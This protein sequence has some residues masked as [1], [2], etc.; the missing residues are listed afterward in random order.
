MIQK[1]TAVLTAMALVLTCTACAPK[2]TR[3]EAEFLL[4][5]DTVTKI[6]S[7]SDSKEAFTEQAQFVHDELEKY[8]QLYDIYNDYAGINNMKTINDNAGKAPVK[9]DEKIIDLLLLAKEMNE[10]TDG[11]MNIALGGVLSLWHDARTAG[12]DDPQNAALPPIEALRA[13]AEH[14]DISH[15]VIDEAASTVYLDDPA[16]KLDV[17]SI[18]KGYAT[19]QVCRAAEERGITSM[20]VSVGGNVRAIGAKDAKG[21]PWNVGVQHPDRPEELLRTVY[22][23]GMSLVTSG[24]YQRYYTV[25]GKPYHHIIDP[26]TLMPSAYFKAVTILCPDSGMADALSTSVF[27]MP[28]EQGKALVESQPQTE[29]LWVLHDGSVVYSGGFEAFLSDK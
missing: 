18:G 13:A 9:V 29:A 10:K 6:I 2:K 22:I 21:T 14:T 16:L 28:L 19:E 4:L 25:E 15:V 1:L 23:S 24:C 17:G 12:I 20:L 26:D 7:Y 11:K 5:F 3:Y 27:N 8:H